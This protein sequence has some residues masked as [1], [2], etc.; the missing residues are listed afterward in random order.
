[1]RRI[2]IK[3]FQKIAL[4]TLAAFDAYCTKH[5]IQYSLSNGTLI[6]AIRHHGFIPWDD[7]SDVIMTRPEYNKLSAAWKKD[8]LPGYEL[9]TD[10]TPNRFYAGECG[11]F[12]ASWTAPPCH[13]DWDVGI[14]TDIYVMD[15]LPN[16]PA[17]VVVH[18]YTCRRLGRCYHSLA[19]REKKLQKLFAHAPFLQPER[20]L[21]KLDTKL[22]SYPVEE[23]HEIACII[24]TRKNLTQRRV[25]KHFFDH[26]IFGLLKHF[27]F[28]LSPNTTNS[29]DNS[30]AIIWKFLLNTN[31]E[32]IPIIGIYPNKK[33]SHDGFFHLSGILYGRTVFIILFWRILTVSP[34][35]QMQKNAGNNLF[36]IIKSMTACFNK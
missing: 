31:G 3:E 24:G 4:D 1:M 22:S 26:F 19:K 18:Y 2:T 33:P 27:H 16:D 36:G 25:P 9:F 17:Q 28:P 8:P 29:Y 14:A 11:K 34:D 6:G 21:A 30:T 13:N 15:G 7:D 12:F 5:N 23:A 35:V 20:I 32:F 10:R